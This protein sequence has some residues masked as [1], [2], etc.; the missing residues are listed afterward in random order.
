MKQTFCQSSN[1]LK[2]KHLLIVTEQTFCNQGMSCPNGTEEINCLLKNNLN[3]QLNKYIRLLNSPYL[4]CY[5]GI[6]FL[7]QQ[8]MLYIEVFRVIIQ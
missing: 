8:K 2:R 1:S 6:H 7:I 5:K 3:M 4:R